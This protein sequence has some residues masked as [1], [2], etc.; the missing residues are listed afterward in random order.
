MPTRTRS[1]SHTNW[2]QLFE[3]L[4]MRF[5]W[6]WCPII[7]QWHYSAL[8]WPTLHTDRHTSQVNNRRPMTY[9][10]GL[11][12]WTRGLH[13]DRRTRYGEK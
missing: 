13:W 7:G 9:F 6:C 11:R 1:G 12:T 10:V 8:Y 2:H 5:G 4:G 3:L